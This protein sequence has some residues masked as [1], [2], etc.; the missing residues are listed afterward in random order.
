MVVW[1]AASPALAQSELESLAAKSAVVAS[2]R[3]LQ[4][5]V[6]VGSGICTSG[7]S[8]GRCGCAPTPGWSRP[9]CCVAMLGIRPRSMS[10]FYSKN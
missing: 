5:R 9:V 10:Y 1:L 7:H 2:V 6:D 3:V 8:A 4:C